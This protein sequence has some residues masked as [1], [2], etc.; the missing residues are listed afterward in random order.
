MGMGRKS[1]ATAMQD[2]RVRAR[3]GS[4]YA[5]FQGVEGAGKGASRAVR[6][7][8][9]WWMVGGWFCV[10]ACPPPPEAAIS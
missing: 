2:A 3:M 9:G 6:Y 10:G 4:A 5:P 1:R 8:M 7:V